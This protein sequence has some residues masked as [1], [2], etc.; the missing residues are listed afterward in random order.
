VGHLWRLRVRLADRAGALGQAASIVGVHGGNIL[1][2]DVHRTANAD[3]VD[4]LVVEFPDDPDLDELRHDLTTSAGTTLCGESKAEAVD[5]VVSTLDHVGSILQVTGTEIN[6]ALEAALGNA[7][8]CK[9]IWAAR[10][11]EA[12]SYELGRAALDQHQAVSG[13]TTDVP[14]QVGAELGAEVALLAVAH[15]P[16]GGGTVVFFAARQVPLDFTASELSRVE[17]LLRV[18]NQIT[19][20]QARP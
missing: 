16:D 13:R 2:I 18:Q 12:R 9:N 7:C 19:K 5:L 6:K 1:S 20:L 10:E 17:A 14:A 15:Q 3:A 4:D 8:C 11:D